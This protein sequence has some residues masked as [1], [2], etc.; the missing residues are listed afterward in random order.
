M[1]RSHPPIGMDDKTRNI[2][3]IAR[4]VGLPCGRLDAFLK[5][6]EMCGYKVMTVAGDRETPA[7]NAAPRVTPGETGPHSLQCGDEEK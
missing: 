1:R 4:F 6:M 5:V 3:D 2:Y 7:V